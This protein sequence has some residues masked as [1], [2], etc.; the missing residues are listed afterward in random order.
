MLNHLL[1][2]D[3]PKQCVRLLKD[4]GTQVELPYY[5]EER[6]PSLTAADA[7]AFLSE[8]KKYIKNEKR[9]YLTQK[10]AS[11]QSM[12]DSLNEDG[13]DEVEWPII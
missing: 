4:D 9:K 12:I 1:G 10:L 3:D 13:E 8:P 6:V 5:H 11:I 2:D 7:L